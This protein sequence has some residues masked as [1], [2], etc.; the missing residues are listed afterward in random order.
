MEEKNN[1]NLIILA[2]GIV[3]V[4]LGFFAYLAYIQNRDKQLKTQQNYEPQFISL[5]QNQ[6][7]ILTNQQEQINKLISLNNNIK[8]IDNNIKPDT[9]IYVSDN[10]PYTKNINTLAGSAISIKST[11]QDKIRQDKFGLL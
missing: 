3:G 2:L 11:P 9:T 4:A 5:M 8:I 1:N 10:K 6:E 7:R